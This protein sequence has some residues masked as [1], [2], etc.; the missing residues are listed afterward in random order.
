LVL[1]ALLQ[2]QKLDAIVITTKVNIRYYSGFSGSNCLL[3]VDAKGATLF[4]DPRYTLQAQQESSYPVKIATG[5]LLKAA[6]QL[7][8]RRKARR[9]GIE[10]TRISHLFYSG[11]A[12]FGKLVPLGKEIET[13]RYVKSAEEIG[14]IRASVK[15]NS[16]ALARGL[17]RFRV[18]MKESDLAAEIEYQMRKLGASGPA[19]DT[20]VAGGAHSALPHAQPRPV[21]IERGGYLLID[22]GA[23][24]NGYMSDMTRTF[25]VGEMP[26]R[27]KDIYEAVLEA[28]LAAIDAV[29]PGRL[30]GQ[31]HAAAVKVLRKQGL[32]KF[33]IHSTGHG[34][35][36]EIHEAPRLGRNDKTPLVAGMAIT[37]EPGVYVEGFG[38]VR[39]EDT[40]LV[41]AT[42]VETL[43]QSP[44]AWTI[45]G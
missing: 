9:I 12:E 10:D 4:T 35:G 37:I 20:I 24:R 33:F 28:H 30:A 13:P 8:R 25:G 38:G 43:T 21:P 6:G 18:G 41:T 44:K 11:L 42:G 15:L 27:A 19:F 22:M 39:I 7:L 40:V 2:S 3:V 34:L 29:K 23:C 17:K 45:L 1:T 16:D 5:S 36:L 26:Q 31:I 14:K 32:D